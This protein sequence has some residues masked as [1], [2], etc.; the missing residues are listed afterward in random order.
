MAAPPP[1]SLPPGLARKVKRCASL[2][3]ESPEIGLALAEASHVGAKEA[4]EGAAEEAGAM[5]R[6]LIRGIAERGLEINEAYLRASEVAQSAL[7]ALDGEIASIARACS[8]VTAS[9][10]ETRAQTASLAEAAVALQTE[11]EVNAKKT[12]LVK[13]FLQKYQL[14]ADEV[15][16]LSFETPGDAFFAALKRVCVVQENARQ[17][18]RTH[19]QR[20]GLELMDGMAAHQEAAYE[21]LCRWLQAGCRALGESEAPEVA[22][23]LRR[24][25]AS[26]RA[27]PALFA[28]CVEEVSNARHSAVFRRFVAAL[29][30]GGPDGVPRPIEVHAGEPLRYVGDMLGWLHQSM[31]TERELLEALLVG[32]GEEVVDDIATDEDALSPTAALATALAKVA[33]G[34]CRPFQ[35]RV[36]QSLAPQSGRAL[37]PDTALRMANLLRFYHGLIGSVVMAAEVHA[38]SPLTS[39]LAHCEDAARTRALEDVRARGSRSKRAAFAVPRDLGAP[40]VVAEGARLATSLVEAQAAAPTSEGDEAAAA[41]GAARFDEL[42]GAAVVPIIEAAAA[43][44]Q[45]EAAAR[46]SAFL[47]N[48]HDAIIRPLER[49]AAPLSAPPKALDELRTGRDAAVAA[50]AEAAV[51]ETLEASGLEERARRIAAYGPDDTLTGDA[52][53]APAVLGEALRAAFRAIGG[54]TPSALDALASGAMR[55]AAGSKYANTIIEAYEPVVEA[56]RT[57][58]GE[59]GAAEAAKTASA[60]DV[61]TVLG[62]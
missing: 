26:L 47:A 22:P 10:R 62:L 30:R 18:L 2:R 13:E 58:L 42:L 53:L 12:D 11:L 55:D 4:G 40:P 3:L 57:R 43:A 17:L 32:D 23:G 29:T 28:Y 6:S 16:A 25:A 49:A 48:V 14:T 44:A 7:D 35:V 41:E 51:R 59:A 50:T 15:A 21:R 54:E 46:R 52:E 33:E 61:R 1:S 38:D 31:A 56:L 8:S 39:S 37:S 60:R 19:H 24:A 20:A 36:E 5:R 45:G 9:V 27:R 34:V